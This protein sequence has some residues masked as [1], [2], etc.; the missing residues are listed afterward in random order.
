MQH[1]VVAGPR[2]HRKGHSEQRHP[3]E[4]LDP[5][6][7]AAEP[8]HF[9]GDDGDGQTAEILDQLLIWTIDL[10]INPKSDV[11]HG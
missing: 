7:H 1:Q 10:R 5:R 4:G 6:V 11:G 3:V 8:I 2:F 9:I